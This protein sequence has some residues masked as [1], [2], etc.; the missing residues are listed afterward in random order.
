MQN[1]FL[2]LTAFCLAAALFLAAASGSAQVLSTLYSIDDAT[3]D[4]NRTAGLLLSSNAFYATTVG[5][6]SSSVKGGMRASGG[7][8]FK[9]NTDGTGFTNLYIFS[10]VDQYSLTNTDGANSDSAAQLA[11]S[12]N[13]LYG[14]MGQG[15]FYANGIVFA[16]NT[17]GTG[18]TNL[19]NFS[20]SAVDSDTGFETNSDGFT[21]DGLVL[22]GN[23]LY[24]ATG[25]GG[26]LGG[27][28]VFAMNTDG[29]GFTNLYNF[30]PT[31]DDGSGLK[32]IIL[33]GNTLYGTTGN[34]GSSANGT[35]FAVNTDGTGFTNLHSFSSL[36]LMTNAP[37]LY[38]N[39][40]GAIPEGGLVLSGDKLYGTATEGGSGT[41]DSSSRTAYGTVFALNTDGSG[42]TNLHSFNYTDGDSPS[43]ALVLSGSTLY[44]TAALGGSITSQQNG[45]VFA[46]NTD[47][48]GFATLHTFTPR[49]YGAALGRSTNADGS[50]PRA[51][52]VVSGNT[53]YGTTE[54][55]GTNGLGTVFA[56]DLVA[57]LPAVE[58]TA[59]PTNGIVRLA[60]QFNCPAVD[61][62]GNTILSWNWNFGDGSNSTSIAQNPT[63]TYTNSGTFFPSLICVNNNGNTVAGTGPAIVVINSILR[64]GGFETGTF[65]NWTLSGFTADSRV[66]TG[67]AFAYSGKYG[68]ELVTLKTMG[69]LSQTL[70]TIPGMDYSISFWLD[71]Q[72]TSSNEFEVSWNGNALLNLTNVG[73]IG[74][75]NIQLTVMA[76]ATN[77]TLQF[78]Y[79]TRGVYFGLDE[80]SV[81]LEGSAQP[82]I[83]QIALSGTNL[84]ISGSGGQSGQ[85][86]Y[87]L[88]GTN[89]AE[90][91]NEW[92]PVATNVPGTNGSFAIFATNAVSPNAR[93]RFYI[94]QSP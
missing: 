49:I 21:P 41:N 13:R 66:T 19:H 53:L 62:G 45:T 2:R 54:D 78:G 46:I 23:T 32:T 59:N 89:L 83:S 85:T 26:T 68:A 93:Q 11:S 94:L 35:V 57:A 38:T 47:G 61:A 48:T 77:S 28:A 5:A 20:A 4:I 24:G 42:F 9:L 18:F 84:V 74:W 34:G 55:G 7:A 15:G 30:N 69:F 16:I 60:V 75:T 25:G 86:Y 87:L 63:H 88:M 12:S 22:S 64:N 82:G 56:L 51:S 33:S 29:S 72:F 76:A 27:G 6:G 67:S 73:N 52:L 10:P 3:N 44:G 8:V 31:N 1:Y 79:L 70:S 90:P 91:L 43:A 65:T 71:S 92:V 37:Y 58:F 50:T 36:V 40:D 81:E 14:T 39:S 17:D 80:I